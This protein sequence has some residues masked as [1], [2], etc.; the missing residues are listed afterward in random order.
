MQKVKR[1][2]FIGLIGFIL[3]G[4]SSVKVTTD[5]APGTSFAHYQTYL[6]A[7]VAEKI[8]LSPSSELALRE[9]LKTQLALRQIQE[10]DKNADVHVVRH[11]STKDKMNVTQFNGAGF[12]SIPYGYGYYRVWGGAPETYVSQYTEGT[13]ILDFV[14]A[15]T[16][17]L[18]F[19]GVA[20]GTV[21]DPETNAKRLAEAVERIVQKL[22]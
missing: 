15:K 17:Q 22:P 6:L 13:L 9:T 14:D 18:V 10:T 5:A 20:T 19:R 1:L 12:R 11:I 7:P 8:G 21:Q 2:L 16:Q 4:C 3:N